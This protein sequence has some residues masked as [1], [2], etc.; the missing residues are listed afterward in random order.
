M[1][2]DELFNEWK[3]GKYGYPTGPYGDRQAVRDEQEVAAAEDDSLISTGAEQGRSEAA[4]DMN[5]IMAWIQDQLQQ[6][7]IDLNSDPEIMRLS[8]ID[9]DKALLLK[10]QKLVAAQEELMNKYLS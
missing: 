3:D 2:F 7:N 10:Q 8:E 9:N 1:K 4:V 5:Q 6:Y